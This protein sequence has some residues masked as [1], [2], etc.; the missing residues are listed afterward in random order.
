[1]RNSQRNQELARKAQ[2][3]ALETRQA[4]LFMQIY[5]RSANDPSFREAM[6]ILSG[7]KINSYEEYQKKGEDEAFDSALSRLG[8]YFEGLGVFVKEGY[9]DI[10]LVALLMTGLLRS[11]WEGI[12][13]SWIEEG[14]K[15]RDYRRWWSEA[16][17]LYN[18][19]MKYIEEHPELAT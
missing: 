14:R 12:Y 2:E 17:Y 5:D 8:L 10:K 3:Q 11:W 6:Q 9:I 13:M 7:Q 16:E 1:M 4:Q 18:E 19:L 15:E